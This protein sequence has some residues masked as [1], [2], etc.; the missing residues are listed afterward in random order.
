M[1]SEHGQQEEHGEHRGRYDDICELGAAA[2]IEMANVDHVDLSKSLQ[3]P[4]ARA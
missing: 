3:R 1:E 2:A 4:S